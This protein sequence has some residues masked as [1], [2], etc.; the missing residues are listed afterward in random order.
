MENKDLV[1]QMCDHIAMIQ[2]ALEGKI[3]EIDESID[4]LIDSINYVQKIVEKQDKVIDILIR[5]SNNKAILDELLALEG[6]AGV[7]DTQG[8]SIDCGG[9]ERAI[10]YD[11]DEKKEIELP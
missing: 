6:I 4:K 9:R 10:N 2:N 5:H 7:E 3:P 8:D 1:V 11:N